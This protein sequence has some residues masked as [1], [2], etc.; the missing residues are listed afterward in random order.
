MIVADLVARPAHVVLL[1]KS[2]GNLRMKLNPFFYLF[3]M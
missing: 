1:R 2:L 3:Q